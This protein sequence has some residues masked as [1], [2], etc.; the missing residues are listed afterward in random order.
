MLSMFSL[1]VLTVICTGYNDETGTM[2][3]QDTMWIAL[4]VFVFTAILIVILLDSINTKSSRE[5]VIRNSKDNVLWPVTVSI[6]AFALISHFAWYNDGAWTI[7]KGDGI[8]LATGA[9]GLVGFIFALFTS[10]PP[11]KRRINHA[12]AMPFRRRFR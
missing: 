9:L 2:P 4:G 3:R 12:C 5:S 7:S 8:W 11:R 1:L 6:S 10:K